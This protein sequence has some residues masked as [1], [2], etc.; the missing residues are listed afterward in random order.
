MNMSSVLDDR[1]DPPSGGD[2]ASAEAMVHR[3]A[4]KLG[5]TWLC[6][7]EV[8]LLCDEEAESTQLVR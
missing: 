5:G 8:I 1:H 3:E 7:P 2:T 6:E 4:T